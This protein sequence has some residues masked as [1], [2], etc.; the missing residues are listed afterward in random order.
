MSRGSQQDLSPEL[1]EKLVRKAIDCGASDAEVIGIARTE[2]NVEVRLGEVEKLTEAASRGIGLRVLRHG[3]QASCSTS[4]T[5]PE[6]L[7]ELVMT[8]VELASRTS[9]DEAA[10]LPSA[11][12]LAK[13]IPDLG[14]CDPA[15]AAIPTETR[16]E[17]ARRAE[18]AARATDPRI[19]N[20]EGASC[21]T[22][23]S[24]LTLVSSAGFTG[25]YRGSLCSL[26][27][28]PIARQEEQMQIG[29]WGDRR[30]N[31]RDLDS[32]EEIGTTAARRA[33]RKLGA[34]KVATGTFPVVFESTAAEDLLRDLFE[35]VN[36]GAIFRR[37]SFLVGRLGETIASPLVTIVDDG[38][39]PGGIGSRPFDGDGL[40]ARRTVVINQGVLD[41]YL[42]NTYTARKLNL[43]STG[44]AT[45]GLT[46]APSIDVGN[47]FLAPGVCSPEEVIGS[48]ANGFYVTE[49]I[50]FGFNPVTGDY[51]RGAAG[52][53]I[54]DG[55]L[56]F[57]VEEVTIA[58][59]MREML[60]GIEMVGND[61]RFRG[62]IASPTIKIDRMTVSGD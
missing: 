16:V 38:L 41:S 1:L 15:V 4:D 42:L 24:T 58:G 54:I 33:L 28:A 30:R 43:A 9:V 22:V 2:F 26:G 46:G 59:N 56:A 45:R 17:L 49:T 8:A 29:Y 3:R 36:G 31:L 39:M 37:A 32:P 60:R 10:I 23:T 19:V 21:S 25:S 5:S 35:A 11:G 55:Q 7:D 40:A 12:E 51:S 61:L 57:P 6:A 18:D 27:V 50:G 53:W 52:W 13:T 20:S 48:V 47:L 14:L 62:R 34:R 44:N